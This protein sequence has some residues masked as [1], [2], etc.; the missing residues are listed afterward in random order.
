MTIGGAARQ[1]SIGA[2]V[3]RWQVVA[4]HKSLALSLS[5]FPNCQNAT[6]SFIQIAKN[7][8]KFMV[9][10]IKFAEK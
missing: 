3:E 1:A 8:V 5:A 2:E 4:L 7:R 9:E 10:R 6:R